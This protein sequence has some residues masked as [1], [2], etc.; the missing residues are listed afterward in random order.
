MSSKLDCRNDNRVWAAIRK[1]DEHIVGL[2][3]NLMFSKDGQQSVLSLRGSE[4]ES[5]LN[6]L[7]KVCP[8]TV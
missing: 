5:F 3:K 4:A 8:T 7:D 6:L 1:D 2:L